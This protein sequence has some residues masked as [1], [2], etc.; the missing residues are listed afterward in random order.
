MKVLGIDIGGSGIKGAPVNTDSGEMLAE[1]FRK[2]T[3][4][5]SRPN[6]V[7]SAILELVNHFSWSGP[8]GCGFPSV[9]IHGKVFTAANID[10]SWINTDAAALIT[11]VSGCQTTLIN[12][13]DAAG[14]AEMKFGAG[15]D[16]TNGVVLMVTLGT[17]IGTALFTDRKLLPN[18]ELGHLDIRGKDAERRASDATRQAKKLTWEE[19]S[20][21]LNEYL[22][23]MEKL[24]WP[25][26]IIVGG[27]VSKEYK[28]FFP[29]L[30]VRAKIVPALLLNNAGIV[31]AALSAAGPL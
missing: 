1:R 16:F 4:E 25:E 14:M 10:E 3:P 9:V 13:A 18:T 2:P 19:W 31:G 28:K 8:I 23:T 21:R 11:A 24:F 6:E 29:F 17:G 22:Q 26:L 12:D 7:A 5:P 30:R 27:G 15:K 20:D